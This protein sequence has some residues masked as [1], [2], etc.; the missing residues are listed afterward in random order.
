MA[1]EIVGCT[2][3]DTPDGGAGAGAKTTFAVLEAT[4]IHTNILSYDYFKLADDKTIGLERTATLIKQARQEF[5][6]SILVDNGDTI[7]G[8][9]LAD[10][11]AIVHPVAC[12]QALA[13]YKTMNA[14]GFEIGG[15]G[16]HEFNYGLAYLSQVTHTPFDV[17]GVD[18]GSTANCK[19][20]EFPQVLS[21]VFSAK[22]N[23]TIF[24]ASAIIEKT[25][26]ATGSD[27]KTVQT[28]LKVG[29]LAFTPPAI[30][31]W[32]KRWLDGKVYTKGV[33]EVA[34]GIVQDLRAKGADL[35]VAI[36]HGGISASVDTTTTTPSTVP[37]PYSPTLE[38]PAYYLAQVPGIDAM[39]MGHSHLVF[40]DPATTV[41]GFK[42]QN[43]DKTTGNVN[44]V[45]SIMA[46]FWGQH[47]GV[48]K[49]S[50]AFDGSHWSVDKT[51][52]VVDPRPIV[53]S[54]TGGKPVACDA[55]GNW[56]TGAT[57]AF[58]TACTGLADKTKVYIGADP[59]IATLVN[60]E[61]QDTV[62]YV[63]TPIG[64][65]DFEMA[66]YFAELGDP[67]AIQ[68]VNQAQAD[69]VSNYVKNYLP[70][71]KDLPVLSVSAPFKSGFQG[72]N[73][74]TDVAGPNVAINNAADL[75]LFAN[76]IY[77]VKVTGQTLIDWL[78]TAAT[79]F[80][81]IDPAKTT[82]QE[83]INPGQPGYNFDTFTS[84]DISYQIDVT[85]PL[86]ASGQKASGRITGLTYKGVAIKPEAEFIVATNNYRA[87][88]GGNFP[89]LDGSN[90]IYASPDTNRDVLIAYIKN[91]THLT[92][93]ANGSAR[94][95]SF[96]QV[97]PKPKGRVPL[98]STK[99]KLPLATAAGISNVTLA[100]D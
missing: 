25:V 92:R 70:Q 55:N 77:A 22:T 60:T 9:V 63:K 49:L 56:R 13:V 72:G 21:N 99:G 88:G 67:T 94:S 97:L 36:I 41:P 30:L 73:D 3:D 89:G 62:A 86:P 76:T 16:N 52:T 96:V 12:D 19:G 61:H 50:L 82:D 79:R 5:P 80:N 84:P 11:Q 69:Y 54:C 44:G 6:N 10:V 51:G 93:A 17:D 33:Q 28:K 91:T 34:A 20:P 78:E 46:N 26:S 98:H 95:W 83:L 81:Q 68:I 14:L 35:V 31:N 90:T 43:V 7:Q 1:L 85:K 38:N 23:Q 8:T 2:G 29:F 59:D 64:D 65:T 47:L 45:P 4:D 71:Y 53:T 32:D 58:A 24:P 37:T 100:S 40:P 27:G 74:Y 75:Y 57:C 18:A 42:M 87:S 15:I 39:L 66:S 48:I